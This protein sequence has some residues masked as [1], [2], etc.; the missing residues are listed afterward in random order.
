MHRAM[1]ISLGATAL[2]WPLGLDVDIQD[3][4]E[5]TYAEIAR[6]MVET[7]EWRDQPCNY[8]PWFGHPILSMWV[9]ALGMKLFGATALGSRIPAA[10]EVLLLVGVT[11]VLGRW[12]WG[13]A[14]AAAGAALCA[15]LPAMSLMGHNVKTDLN[16]MVA[17]S[18][19]I[20]LGARAL[21]RPWL[22]VPTGIC[23]GLG[24][25]TKGPFGL[26]MPGAVVLAT[27]AWERRWRDLGRGWPWI[28]AGL[29]AFVA[30]FLPWN[31]FMWNRWG[32]PWFDSL[33]MDSTVRRFAGTN[34]SDGTTPL[35]FLHTLLWAAAPAVPTALL[36]LMTRLRELR[37]HLTRPPWP[38]LDLTWFFIPLVVMSLSSMKLPHYIF[39]VIPAL[40]AMAGRGAVELFAGRTS[41]RAELAVRVGTV[42]ISAM[43]VLFALAM[44]TFTFPPPE[45]VGLLVLFLVGATVVVVLLVRAWRREPTAMI[46]SICVAA[47]LAMGLHN[48]AARP[49][50]S[51]YS[52]ARMVAQVLDEDQAPRQRGTT[53]LTFT[54]IWR[55]AIPF[56]AHMRLEET[57]LGRIQREAGAKPI[58]VL[59]NLDNLRELHANGF[60][61]RTRGFAFSYKTSRLSIPFSLVGNR[62]DMATPLLLVQVWRREA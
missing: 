2:L 8:G 21:D 14:E 48:G 6:E 20:M 35:Y 9:M 34:S 3:H 52:P 41:P 22:W 55:M 10:F 18:G 29:I 24:M 57:D 30:T 4:D 40:C 51:R 7:G 25:L 28:I 47:A 23:A 27:L 32:P 56:Y 54:E 45:G 17:T 43:L 16:L 36:A 50:L 19:A 38:V 5:A 33:Y 44:I 26:A 39:P 31:L 46:A 49:E 11:Y 60:A 53:V 1:W 58:Y 37:G 42:F 62:E 61:T 13:R 12:L 59:V 15:A